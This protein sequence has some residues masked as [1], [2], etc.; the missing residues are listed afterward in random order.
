MN[1]RHD[2]EALSKI[3]RAITVGVPI[4]V[5]VIHVQQHYDGIKMSSPQPVVMHPGQFGWDLAQVM[6]SGTIAA[7]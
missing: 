5:A 7:R 3:W 4:L 6:R 1:G 2:V